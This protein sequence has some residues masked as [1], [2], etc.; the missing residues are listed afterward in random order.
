MNIA[1]PLVDQYSALGVLVFCV[2]P[3]FGQAN[4]ATVELNISPVMPSL[5][6]NYIYVCDWSLML[7]RVCIDLNFFCRSVQ[8]LIIIIYFYR[9]LTMDQSDIVQ[10]RFKLASP[11][12][13]LLL[14]QAQVVRIRPSS[15]PP[16]MLLLYPTSLHLEMHLRCNRGGG[17]N[18]KDRSAYSVIFGPGIH[19]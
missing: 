10:P 2:V 3:P 13:S 5:W 8:M 16:V 19:I 4:T 11:P 15:L 6:Y 1:L 9:A 7:R 17:P 12:G 14:T 18:F